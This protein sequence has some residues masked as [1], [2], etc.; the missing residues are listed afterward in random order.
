MLSFS[1]LCLS[2][3][4]AE[5]HRAHLCVTEKKCLNDGCEKAPNVGSGGGRR[6]RLFISFGRW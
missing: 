6:D 1:T 3:S 5:Q 2:E 4:L